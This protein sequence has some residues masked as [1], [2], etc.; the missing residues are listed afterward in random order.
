MIQRHV[1]YAEHNNIIT[2]MQPFLHYMKI[3]VNVRWE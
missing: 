3:T 1:E 2:F